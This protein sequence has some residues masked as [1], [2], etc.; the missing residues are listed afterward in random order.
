MTGGAGRQNE[1]KWEGAMNR[2]RCA[3][4]FATIRAR[5]AELRRHDAQ[6]P[7]NEDVQPVTEPSVSPDRGGSVSVQRPG[8][9]GWR[10]ARQKRRVS[11]DG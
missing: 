5:V 7:G 8:I 11:E 2:P 10:V 9:P 4:D 6:S 1:E 3:D